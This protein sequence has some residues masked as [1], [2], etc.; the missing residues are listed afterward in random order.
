VLSA[1]WFGCHPDQLTSEQRMLLM[2]ILL[3]VHR[4]TV[5]GRAAQPQAG[6]LASVT[7]RWCGC[8]P[9]ELPANARVALVSEIVEAN[10]SMIFGK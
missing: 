2:R 3:D 6:V 10:R 9:S 7:A 5:A 1:Q 4:D 8:A